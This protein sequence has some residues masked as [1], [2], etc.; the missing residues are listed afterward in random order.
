MLIR[1]QSTEGIKRIEC[2]ATENVFTLFLKIENTLGGLN[3]AKWKIYLQRNRTDEIHKSEKRLSSLNLKHGDMVYLVVNET[4]NDSVDS[5]SIAEAKQSS[6]SVNVV[7][8]E[9][10]QKMWKMDGRIK[11]GDESKGMFKLENLSVEPWDENY[12]HEKEIK[13]MSFHAY[14][15]KQTSGVDKGKYLKLENFKAACKIN[16]DDVKRSMMH[17]PS[18]LTLNRQKFRHVDNIVF[19][20]REIVDRFLNYWRISGHQR[21]GYLYGR[22]VPHSDVPLGIRAEVCAIYEPPQESTVNSLR[23]HPDPSEDKVEQIAKKLGLKKVGWIVTD[24]LATDNK[25]GTVKNT[26]NS[27]TYFLS[28]E[29]CITAATFQNENLNPC[30]LA[31]NGFY[32]SKFCTVVVSGDKECHISF[33]GYQVSNQ[34]MSLVSDNCLLPTIDAPELGYVRESSADLFV[35][36][37]YYKEKDEYG[38]EIT[39]PARPLPLE[40]L[41]IDVRF[42]FWCIAFCFS[43]CLVQGCTTEGMFS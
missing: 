17:L 39:K 18:A 6:I 5:C 25:K 33:E 32:G 26:R 2:S 16:N 22:Y 1:V 9:I 34:C 43:H 10:D 12:L 7:E 24:L 19:E 28:A 27:D 29:E 20:N 14:M 36:D 40:Y 21:M 23:F 37:V 15:R 11:Q 4:A 8:D 42:N 30:R 38:N 3:Q 13:F 35:S 41:L 31:S